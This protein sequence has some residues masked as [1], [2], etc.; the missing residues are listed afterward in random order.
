MPDLS[1]DEVFASHMLSDDI[2]VFRRSETIGDNGRSVIAVSETF[3]T[4]G[5]VVPGA[6]DDLERGSDK[7]FMRKT[8][9]ITTPFR[10]QGPA[11]GFQPD[12]V[13]WHGDS[14]IVTNVSDYTGFAGGF[15]VATVQSVDFIDQPPPA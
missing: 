13:S 12:I 15:V 10:L 7:Q 4:W 8:L 6:P 1:V 2:V 3:A 5:V 14:F 9:S 11:D